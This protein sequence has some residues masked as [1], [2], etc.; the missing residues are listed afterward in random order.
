ML[1]AEA[2]EKHTSRRKQPLSTGSEW[3][4]ELLDLYDREFARLADKIPAGHL[5]Q[6]D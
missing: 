3:T 1:V 4:F 2:P 6:P 5:P